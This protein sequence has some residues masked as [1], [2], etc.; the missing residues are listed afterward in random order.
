MRRRDAMGRRS[1]ATLLPGW[2]AV[3]TCLVA[4]VLALVGPRSP[5]AAAQQPRGS[6]DA[7]TDGAAPSASPSASPSA[8][9]SATP[10]AAVVTVAGKGGL[11]PMPGD[12]VGMALQVFAF[13]LVIVAAL[14]VPPPLRAAE[15]NAR[16]A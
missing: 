4:L 15:A 6:S 7:G 12:T 3:I 11:Y 9:P 1:A 2:A 16:L 13:A 14:I 8:L 5:D 10:S